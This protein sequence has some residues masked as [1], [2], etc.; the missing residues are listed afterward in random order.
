MRPVVLTKSL[1]A[2]NAALLAA[3]QVPI[4]GTVLTL[5]GTALDTSR[6]LLLTYGNEVAPRTL[7]LT[8]TDGSG[9]PITETLAVPSG[10]IG[11]VATK[12]DFATLA[13]AMPGGGGWTSGM[14]VGTNGTGSTPWAVPDS[15]I[16]TPDIGIQADL[17]SGA[18]TFSIE[19]T[20]DDVKAPI[21]IYQPGYSQAMPVPVPFGWA[22]LTGIAASTQGIINGPVAGWRLTINSGQ[23]A[24]RATGIQSGLTTA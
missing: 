6:R 12:Q 3:L 13:S 4:S 10:G 1:A 18:A 19:T 8:G 17:L 14:S 15:F 9:T 22:G 20:I 16:E 21:G 11:T 2:A 5:T 24:V 23:G 7:L